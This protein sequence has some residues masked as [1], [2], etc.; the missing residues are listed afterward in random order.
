MLTPVMV[1]DG[2][3]TVSTALPLVDPP[4][5]GLFTVN[6]PVAA[7]SKS[8]A[9]NITCNATALT[10]TVG[11]GEPF[12]RTTELASK[13]LPV[14]VMVAGAPV[15]TS[16]GE[17]AERTGSGLVT[18]KGV[19]PDAPPPGEPFVT[20]TMFA[21]LPAMLGAGSAACSSVELSRVV[22]SGAPFQFTT[23]EGTNPEP[24]TSS[25]TAL[26]PATTLTGLTDFTTGWGLLT[27]NVATEETPPPGAGLETVT[28]AVEPLVSPEA[29]SVAVNTVAEVN[30]V[31]SAV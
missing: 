14:N 10:K 18:F 19:C 6:E 22:V 15:G 16:L 4:G 31:D 30:M 5:P 2:W 23:D 8:A 20:V 27:V 11:R 25:V 13:P 7:L 24:V 3:V 12:H 17:I 9:V 26:E 1:G 29:G 21:E 28:P